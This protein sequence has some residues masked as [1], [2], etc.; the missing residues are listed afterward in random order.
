M[1]QILYSRQEGHIVL[2]QIQAYEKLLKFA[3]E[4]NT[5]ILVKE[6]KRL[7]EVCTRSHTLILLKK[8]K[9]RS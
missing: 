5:K 7:T 3:I 8:D 2:N 6:E 4:A 1:T 9:G